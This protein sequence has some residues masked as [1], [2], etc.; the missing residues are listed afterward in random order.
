VKANSRWSTR[1]AQL[2]ALAL[3]VAC[4]AL[5]QPQLDLT[6][7]PAWNGWSRS[8][9]STE[10]FVRVRSAE[11]VHVRVSAKAGAQAVTSDLDL[12][13]GRAVA[14]HMPI[15]SADRITV[16]G[17]LRETPLI[18]HEL[19]IAQSV[20]P[21]LA[22][23][24]A[25]GQ[26]IELEGLH[27]LSVGPESLPR[28]GSA[29]SS[30]DALIIDGGALRA[31]D[32]SQL[33]ALI[34]HTTACGRT[35]LVNVEPAAREVFE[36]AAGCSG[37][38]LMTA[39]SPAQAASVLKASLADTSAAQVES[40]PAR[41]LARI[42]LASWYRALVLLAASFAIVLVALS[43]SSSTIMFVIVPLLAMAALWVCLNAM[44]A[45]SVVAVWAE[46][47][48]GA[49]IARYDAR[50]QVRSLS[51]KPTEIPA[52]ARLG[53]MQA[54]DPNQPMRFNFDAARG[55][56]TSVEF[57]GRLFRSAALCYAGTLPLAR[58]IAIDATSDSAVDVRNAG[59]LAW[60]SGVLIARRD[61]YPLPALGPGD[62]A[63]IST[64]AN[65]SAPGPAV[66]SAL[67]RMPTDGL[68]A[69][70]EL[71]PAAI[72]DSAGRVTAWLFVP[73]P[74]R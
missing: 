70:W 74:R 50:Q 17:E 36:N 32:S 23:A 10:I 26:A 27:T 72:A 30:I 42:D 71:D 38:L 13:P 6:A 51:R 69:L 56:T 48:S 34:A 18:N 62:R 43:F 49:R 66:R 15:A 68:A 40:T 24:M 64:H 3:C 52:L 4:D 29:F 61:A 33:D 46:A 67:A 53:S 31:L 57:E 37:R 63:T 28:N 12:E 9:R 2:F 41:D 5:A 60:P 73:I 47:E 25:S 8:G 58:S 14:L 22:V 35:V 55:L 54:C 20:A 45:V 39:T 11:R 16:T 65:H 59:R 44:E 1:S 19:R 7:T 21:L